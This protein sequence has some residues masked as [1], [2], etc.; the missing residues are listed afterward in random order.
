LLNEKFGDI[1]KHGAIVPVD[2]LGQ[3][4]FCRYASPQKCPKPNDS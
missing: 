4:H 3:G 1:V 2:L